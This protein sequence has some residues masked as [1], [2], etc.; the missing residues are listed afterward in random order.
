M[1]IA[2][3]IGSKLRGFGERKIREYKDERAFHA[4]EKVVYKQ[5]ERRGRLKRAAAEGY[6]VGKT[7]PRSKLARASSIIRTDGPDPF[8]IFQNSSPRS[9]PKKRRNSGT[10]IIIQGS[11]ARRRKKRS[12]QNY[13]DQLL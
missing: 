1:G 12:S 9:Q 11:S 6:K 3:K 2:R 13:F 8:G 7:R 10:T 4:Q 5:A